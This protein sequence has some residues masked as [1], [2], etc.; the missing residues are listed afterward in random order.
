MEYGCH[1]RDVCLLFDQRLQLM[2]AEDDP[3]WANWDQ[4]ETA[5]ESQYWTQDPAAVAQELAVAAVQIASSF[6]DVKDD[7]WQ[8]PGRRSNGSVFT[9]DTLGR[10]F[11]HDLVHHVYDLG[12]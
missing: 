7:Q 12:A 2:L 3:L 9:V 6:A 11:V 10:Y 4:D 1:V 8:R 5:L